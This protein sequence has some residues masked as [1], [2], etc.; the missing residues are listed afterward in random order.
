[1]PSFDEENG[2][3]TLPAFGMDSRICYEVNSIQK[4][5]NIYTVNVIEYNIATDF[6]TTEQIISAYNKN[7]DN[8]KELKFSEFRKMKAPTKSKKK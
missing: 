4:S 8:Q 2:D 1:M 3:Y 5:N 6:D 7:D